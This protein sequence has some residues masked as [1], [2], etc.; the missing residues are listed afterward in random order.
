METEILAAEIHVKTK[1][2]EY[3]VQASTTVMDTWEVTHVKV[4]HGAAWDKMGDVA[5]AIQL[6]LNANEKLL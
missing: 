3:K 5:S 2:G 6:K 4:V 1:H